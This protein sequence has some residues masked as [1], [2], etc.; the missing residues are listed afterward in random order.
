MPV[1]TPQQPWNFFLKKSAKLNFF[2]KSGKFCHFSET[3]ILCKMTKFANTLVKNNLNFNA[4][5]LK[6]QPKKMT[7]FV[8][9][10]SKML[11]SAQFNGK[12]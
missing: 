11:H 2:E 3:E 10:I 7:N 12:D 9:F 4:W 6:N 5:W 1:Q 8:I